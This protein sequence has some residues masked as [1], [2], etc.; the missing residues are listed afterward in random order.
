MIGAGEMNYRVRDLDLGGDL[1]ANWEPHVS[2]QGFGD[3]D[4]IGTHQHPACKKTTR[5]HELNGD[6]D[7]DDVTR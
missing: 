1:T 2:V 3:R 4:E 5:W 7:G 6:R